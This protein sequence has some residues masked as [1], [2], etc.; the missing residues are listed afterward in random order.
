M[1]VGW[2]D[3]AGVAIAALVALA[4]IAGA[5]SVLVW[6]ARRRRVASVVLDV[7]GA[8]ARV[9][10][11]IV[12][13]GAVAGVVALFLSPTTTITGL[14]VSVE[15]PLALPC[16]QPG[17]SGFA[18]PTLY[19]ATIPTATAEIS[20]LSAGVKT[21]LLSGSLFAW[22]LAAVP[23][24]LV[25][26][27]CRL[28][29]AGKPFAGAASRWLMISAVSVLVAGITSEVLLIV[30]RYLAAHEV[31]PGSWTGEAATAPSGFTMTLPLWPIGAALAL[32][33]LAVIF[34]HGARLQRET[35]LMV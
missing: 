6:D 23:G 24:L 13:L 10:V 18:E 4:I 1:N 16:R 14:P 12:A 30:G 17:S 2:G 34:R 7:T 15:W 11:A 25:A 35:D 20:A 22:V 5:L 33:A 27:L 21:I 3:P 9:W 32:A 31:F 29:A 8:V 19:C 28:A 26:M